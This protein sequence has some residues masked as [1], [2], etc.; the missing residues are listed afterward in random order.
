MFL[1]FPVLSQIIKQHNALLPCQVESRLLSSRERR[2]QA[3]LQHSVDSV[4]TENAAHVFSF[5]W[6]VFEH[7]I[8]RIHVGIQQFR[9]VLMKVTNHQMR[10]ALHGAV[11]R[12]QFSQNKLQQS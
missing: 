2:D 11:G 12:S 10:V 3:C 5:H 9:Q 1:I 7:V 8:E 6:V 4:A